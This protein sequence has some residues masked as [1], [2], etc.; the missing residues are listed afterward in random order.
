M[1]QTNLREIDMADISAK[2]YVQ[3]LKEHHA[4]IAMINA[5]GIIA[6]Y[7]TEL[8]YHYQSEYL[9]GDS[10]K[11]IVD[12]CHENGIRV[13]ARVDFSKIRYPIYEA[14]P[15][16]AFRTKDGGIVNYNGD[17]QTCP[18]NDYQQVYALEIIQEM[19]R[20]IPFDGL[21]CNM[22]GFHSRDYSYRSHGVCHCDRCRKGYYEMFA[23]ELPDD[24]DYQ[25]PSVFRYLAYTNRRVKEQHQKL[26]SLLQSISPE[27]AFDHEAYERIE[28][29]TEYRMRPP[30]WPYSAASNTRAIRGDGSRRIVP[31]CTSVDFIGF[32][33]RHVA[34]SPALQEL[35]LWQSL[36]NLGGLDY[37]LIGRMDNH[38]DRSAFERVKKVYMFAEAHESIFRGLAPIADVAILRVH[39]WGYTKEE[40]G[41]IR[42][43]TEAHMLFDEIVY[44]AFSG[45][46]L[47]KYEAVI[48]PDIKVLPGDC[49]KALDTYVEN[50]GILIATGESGLYNDRYEF[51]MKSSLQCLGITVIEKVADDMVSSMLL[52]GEND[53]DL[54]A[55]Y[56]DANV[57]AVGDRYVYADMRPEVTRYLKLIPPHPYGPPERC[58]FTEITKY[59]GICKHPY[60][61]GL[62]IYLPWLPGTFYS[63]DGYRNSCNVMRDVLTIMCGIR[64]IAPKLT[65]MV[66]VT[67]ASGGER[68]FVLQLVNDSGFFGNTYHD[69]LPIPDI[70]IQVETKC[71]P[72]SVRSL[73][74]GRECGYEYADG[75]L[76][77]Q[78]ERLDAYDAIAVRL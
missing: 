74:T 58:Y 35:R 33:Y 66:E 65:P 60:G 78:L 25:D 57:I 63:N 6:S 61:K 53:R 27:I 29:N 50:G 19:F 8:P 62:G 47:G 36:A 72:S 16:W 4:T 64:S 11:T 42:I 14:H 38:L 43:L 39:A 75:M 67:A 41:W 56:T 12:L 45:E 46:W 10:L 48:L 28:A 70:E 34:V 23:E 73:M 71:K 24:M 20:K 2:R 68:R 30:A 22:G 44:T 77:I 54:L 69:P 3:D 15:E 40:Q 76:Y 17:V 26:A 37:Y 7:D 55:S 31:S 32:F 1:I 21:F 5:A 9:Q 49:A 51:Q 13:I 59:P 18:N 52:V